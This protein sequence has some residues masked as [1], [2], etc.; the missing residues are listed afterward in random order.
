MTSEP[1]HELHELTTEQANTASRQIDCL[2]AVE[3]ARLMNAEDAT[4]AT[5]VA[6]E[7]AAIGAAI[8]GIV[9]RMEQGGRLIY[10]GAGTSGRLG[11]LDASECPPTFRTA[12]GQVVGW[13]AG[14]TRVLTHA[15]ERL[16]DDAQAGWDAVAELNIDARDSVVGL[17]ASGRTPFVLGAIDAATERGAFTIGVACNRPSLL[18]ERVQVMIAP[19]TGPE[20][21]AG[22]T[23]LKAGT[24]QKMILN[25]LSTGVMIKLGKT[26]GNLMVDVKASNV[27]LQVRAIRIVREA[28][29]LEREEA[30]AALEA[31]NHETK[32]AIVAV[33]AGISAEEA[34]ALVSSA[35]GSVRVALGEIAP[36]Q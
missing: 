20:V 23:R 31:A 21:I 33:L 36:C 32:T 34:R 35:H 16:E 5:A 2:S 11:V 13:L 10:I 8:E 27:K 18:A 24:A 29:G 26:F 22:S 28:T 4:I 19:V 7:I 30:A 15:S 17:S 25:M 1:A 14:G 9:A 12:P 3:I 6:T